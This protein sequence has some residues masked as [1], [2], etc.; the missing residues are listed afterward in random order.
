MLALDAMKRSPFLHPAWDTIIIQL[1][2]NCAIATY[3]CL[4]ERVATGSG[5]DVEV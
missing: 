2:P 1:F 3:V 5:H 4:G